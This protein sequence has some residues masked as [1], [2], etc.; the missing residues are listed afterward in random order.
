MRRPVGIRALFRQR[1]SS[2]PEPFAP[3]SGGA[4]C[5]VRAVFTRT[6]DP[7]STRHQRDSLLETLVSWGAINPPPRQEGTGEGSAAQ[8]GSVLTCLPGEALGP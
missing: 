3:G 4:R 6:E 2:S 5:L 8:L 7:A 1:R